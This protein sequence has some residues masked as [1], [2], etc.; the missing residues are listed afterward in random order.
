[1]NH[2]GPAFPTHG[3]T[4][5]HD[6]PFWPEP[7]MSIR[8]WF[9]AHAPTEIPH[10][11]EHEPPSRASIPRLVTVDDVTLP[12]HKKIV[13]DWLCDAVC[14]LPEELTWFVD[15]RLAYSEAFDAWERENLRARYFQW[16]WFY[17]DAMLQGWPT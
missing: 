1:M 14:D 17:A 5:P 16:R 10:W 8:Q 4:D 12:E 6:E 9:A 15:M 2:G 7:G 11:F 13:K 3:W